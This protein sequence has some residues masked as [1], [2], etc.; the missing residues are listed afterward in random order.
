ME[1][2][3]RI[4]EQMKDLDKRARNENRALAADEQDQWNRMNAE[5]DQLTAE[6]D[7]LERMNSLEMQMASETTVSASGIM[8]RQMPVE[9]ELTDAEKRRHDWLRILRGQALS[10]EQTMQILADMRGTNV[11]ATD[12]STTYGGYLT[13]YGFSNEL[14]VIMKQFGGMLQAC[15][16]F[17]TPNG[18]AF[19][20]PTVDDTATTAVWYTDPRGSAL[21]QQDLTFSRVTYNAYT[22]GTIAKLSV[23]LAQD[24][25]VNLV[26][27]ILAEIF[28][29]RIG[30][31]L[32]NAFTDGNGSGK[33]TGLLAASGGTSSG[34]TTASSTSITAGELIDLVHSVDPAYRMGPKVGFMM[35]DL[36]LAEIKKLTV[37][38]SDDNP[39]WLL[40]YREGEPDRLLGF[41]YF[42]NQSMASSLVASAKAVAFGDFSKYKIRRVAEPQVI[43]LNERYMDELHIGMVGF[44][45]YDGKLL[46]TS[47][48]KHL[49]MK[50]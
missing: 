5:Y 34:K 24:E 31:S 17:T 30:R 32:N 40:S 41:Q 7:R 50:P 19:Y 28:G 27:Q 47:A 37:G 12:T 16:I 2:R 13:P 29:E 1:K 43:R 35:H 26:P 15:D 44:A 14:E 49:T 25:F 18:Q 46:N 3:A 8:A 23:E 6:R 4:W 11:I 10:P 36:V 39:I 21:T 38:T 42:I 33:P 20:W 9:K 48:I 45:R 22:L